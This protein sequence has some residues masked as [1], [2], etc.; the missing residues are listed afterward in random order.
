MHT[1]P[2]KEKSTVEPCYT[3]RDMTDDNLAVPQPTR[4]L[5]PQRPPGPHLE[6]HPE[7]VLSALRQV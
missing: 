3:P 6:T 4:Y 5:F 7:F 2:K 1:H